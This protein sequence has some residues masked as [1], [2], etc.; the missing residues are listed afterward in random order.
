MTTFAVAA[1]AGAV[2]AGVAVAVAVVAA[3]VVVVAVAAEPH[4]SLQRTAPR[5]VLSCGDAASAEDSAEAARSLVSLV[6]SW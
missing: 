1:A 4:G 2:V 5:A 6:P 3:V